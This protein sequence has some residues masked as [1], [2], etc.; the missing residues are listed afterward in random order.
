LR[1][2]LRSRAHNC[3]LQL[4]YIKPHVWKYN[5][6]YHIKKREFSNTV[7]LYIN[8]NEGSNN[9]S[10]HV[11]VNSSI[12]IKAKGKQIASNYDNLNT[13]KLSE[14]SSS[15]K[16]KNTEFTDLIQKKEDLDIEIMELKEIMK[17]NKLATELDKKLRV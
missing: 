13:N 9:D 12:S 14:Y 3:E 15:E 17:N 5:T 10:H 7:T 8:N 2:S 6:F 1:A 4:L 11:E 16:S